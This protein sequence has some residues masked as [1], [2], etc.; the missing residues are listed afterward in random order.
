M[1]GLSHR[2]P[3][4]PPA[5]HLLCGQARVGRGPGPGHWCS[6]ELRGRRA[7]LGGGLLPFGALLDLRGRHRGG[8]VGPAAPGL[9]R[10]PRHGLSDVE[11]GDNSHRPRGA[12]LA[13]GLHARAQERLGPLGGG[14]LRPAPRRGDARAQ[15]RAADAHDGC[16]QRLAGHSPLHVHAGAAGHQ[17]L[18]RPLQRKELRP[19]LCDP[20]HSRQRPLL[21][22]RALHQG[23][24]LVHRRHVGHDHRRL[25]HGSVRL[26]R[27]LPGLLAAARLHHGPGR[28][29]RCCLH[30]QWEGPRGVLRP[31]AAFPDQVNGGAL[32]LLAGP[33][34]Q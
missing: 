22:P 34:S 24:Y 17:Q 5:L 28:L 3:W 32:S 9:P 13:G 10:L 18:H 30:L 12:A 27:R 25:A 20:R 4:E 14:R 23:R 11:P 16:H 15:A 1:A 19:G 6:H 2:G 31:P 21:Q 7:D 29:L 8:A 26:G 33:A